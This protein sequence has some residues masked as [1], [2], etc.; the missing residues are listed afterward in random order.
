MYSGALSLPGVSQNKYWL[1]PAPPLFSALSVP[2]SS[3]GAHLSG[4]SKPPQHSAITLAEPPG[5][6]A[7]MLRYLSPVPLLSYQ[8][9]ASKLEQGLPKTQV[10]SAES[11]PGPGRAYSTKAPRATIL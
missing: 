7:A 9:A 2:W 3:K 10:Y 1:P 6:Q 8:A 4:R 11:L 5:K